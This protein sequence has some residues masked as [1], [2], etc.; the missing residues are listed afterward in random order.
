MII[1]RLLKV[2][3]RKYYSKHLSIVSCLLPTHLTNK[4][5]EILAC[6]M[7]LDKN[8]IEEDMFNTLARKKVMD[9]LNLKPGGLGN[10]LKSMINK[11]VLDKNPITNKITLKDYLFPDDNNQGYKI[12]IKHE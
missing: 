2:D 5:I 1:Q 11:K 4:E 12:M 3:K 6:F 7:S 8:I 10:H 9:E